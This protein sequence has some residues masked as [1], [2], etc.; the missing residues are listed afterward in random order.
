MTTLMVSRVTPFH[1]APPLSPSQY[2]THGGDCGSSI[3]RGGLPT[4]LR[5]R[6]TTVVGV[7][8]AASGAVVVVVPISPS[9]PSPPAPLPK[10]DDCSVGASW[11]ALLACGLISAMAGGGVCDCVTATMAI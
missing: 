3:C 5:C 11:I 4:H 10:R 8:A 6:G 9:T 1:V 2:G 7:A